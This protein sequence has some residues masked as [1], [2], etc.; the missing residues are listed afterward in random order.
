M[1]KSAEPTEMIKVLT[2]TVE[3]GAYCMTEYEIPQDVLK[4]HGKKLS[5]SEPDIFAI[6]VNHM[7]KKAREVLGI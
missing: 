1:K 5:R 4:K 6:L 7:T 3:E 2:L